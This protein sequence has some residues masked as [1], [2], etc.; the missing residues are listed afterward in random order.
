[1]PKGAFRITF[2]L[3]QLRIGEEP[4]WVK[5]AGFTGRVEFGNRSMS[6]EQT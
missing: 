3:E 6:G 4:R 1:M 2:T 5:K